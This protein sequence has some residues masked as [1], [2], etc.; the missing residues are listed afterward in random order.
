MPAPKTKTGAANGSAKGKT[1]TPA[2]TNGTSTPVPHDT[3][4]DAKTPAGKPD[5]A[6]YDAEQENIKKEIDALQL[7]LNVVRDKIGGAS[8]K[9]T[10]NERRKVLRD[11]LDEIRGQQSDNKAS[12]GKILDQVKT[13]QDGI[14]KKI[15]DLNAAKQKAPFK[16]VAEV[17][18]HVRNLEKQVESGNMRVVDEKRALQEIQQ[19]KRSRRTVESFQADQE[20][21]EAD[22]AKLDELRK[23][24]DDPEFKAISDRYDTIKAELDEIKKVDDEAYANRSKL[25]AERDELQAQINALYNQKRESSRLYREANDRYWTKVNED[26]ARRAERARAQRAA[27]ELAKKQETARRLREEAEIPAFQAEI[28]DCQTLID[29]F[30]GKSGSAAPE[31]KTAQPKDAPEVAGVPKLEIRKVESAPEGAIVRKKKGEEEADYFVAGKKKGKKQPRE[32]P[33]EKAPPADTDKLHVPFAT[34]SALLALSIPP[35]ANHGD[36]PRVI[37]DLGTKKAWFE[38]NQKRVTAENVARAEAEIKRLTGKAEEAKAD[39]DLEEDPN[40]VLPPNGGG[41]RPP[42]LPPTPQV[43]DIKSLPVPSEAVDQELE[44]VAEAEGTASS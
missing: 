37:E 15:K 44:A 20:S 40:T 26:R 12:R 8:G 39:A 42:E 6:A 5:K 38:A 27:D 2:S 1:S 7:K 4:A 32:Q 23:Q 21:I 17:D 41:E 25:F 24:L 9:G 36:V 3:S 31:L 28:E 35:P 22:R 30:S 18:T 29:Y 11:E 33:K 43:D 13:I 10:L 14:Q 16:T 19:L 34:L